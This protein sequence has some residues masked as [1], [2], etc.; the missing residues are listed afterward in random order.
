MQW[1]PG[2]TGGEDAAHVSCSFE[3]GVVALCETMVTAT[4]QRGLPADAR[5]S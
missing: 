1:S 2:W 5:I 3:A 4:T